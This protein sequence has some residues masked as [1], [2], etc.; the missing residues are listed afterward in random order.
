MHGRGIVD[1][2]EDGSQEAR[3][4]RGQLARSLSKGARAEEAAEQRGVPR[5]CDGRRR[6]AKSADGRNDA[7]AVVFERK[8]GVAGERRRRRW[9]TRV[10]AQR[11]GTSGG[12]V[13]RQRGG[14]TAHERGHG[15]RALDWDEVRPA[16]LSQ[17]TKPA[18]GS[19]EA[20]ST[21]PSDG[22]SRAKLLF[23]DGLGDISSRQAGS[24]PASQPASALEKVGNAGCAFPPA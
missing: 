7:P 17:L 13:G 12:S 14:C 15:A 10:M 11:Q 1:G 6:R 2:G 23:I 8:K 24:Q 5:R 9:M 16:T 3:R 21:G 22:W 20:R 18:R 19:R 4:A